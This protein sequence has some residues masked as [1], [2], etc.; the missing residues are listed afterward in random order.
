MWDSQQERVAYDS[1]GIRDN[2]GSFIEDVAELKED[3][4]KGDYL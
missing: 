1:K 2:S 4:P 3:N